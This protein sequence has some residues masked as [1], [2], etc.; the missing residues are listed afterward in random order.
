MTIIDLTHKYLEAQS[1]MNDIIKCL[2]PGAQR[3]KMEQLNDQI[4]NVWAE[5]EAMPA[6]QKNLTIVNY[7]L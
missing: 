7:T 2:H 1:K 4:T 3:V 6:A 5:I